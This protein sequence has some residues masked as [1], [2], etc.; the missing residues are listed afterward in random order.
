M[1]SVGLIPITKI[2]ANGRATTATDYFV[3]MKDFATAP[4]PTAALFD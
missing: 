4:S 2:L 3:E 1:G